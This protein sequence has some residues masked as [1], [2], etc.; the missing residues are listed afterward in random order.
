MNAGSGGGR[1]T[2]TFIE[3]ARRRQIA[4]A[5]IAVLAEEGERGATFVAIARRAGVSPS[6][7]SYHFAS[8]AE[9]LSHVLAQII[10]DMDSAL[11]ADLMHHESPRALLRALIEGQC[12]Y[13]GEHSAAVV[14]LGHLAHGRDPAIAEQLTQHQTKSVVELEELI[15]AGQDAGEFASFD[16]RPTAI[17]LLAALEA[18]P[19][20]LFAHPHT[21]AVAYG[22]EL[23]DLFDA[24]CRRRNS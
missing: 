17:T 11:T 1:S 22:R 23:A 18:V 19:S 24:A 13:F 4:E 7:I 9:L 16:P 6:L 10:G 20:E 5:A 15:A 14:A 8:K 21:D 2:P 12:R 3:Q